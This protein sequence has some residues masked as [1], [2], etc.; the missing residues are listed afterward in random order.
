[1]L[2]LPDVSLMT[3]DSSFQVQL[4]HHLFGFPRPLRV[5]GHLVGA[6]VKTLG[7]ELS[8]WRTVRVSESES[9]SFLIFAMWAPVLGLT[10]R[11]HSAQAEIISKGQGERVAP[12]SDHSC[13]PLLRRLES[14]T[15]S[16]HVRLRRH[17]I[18]PARSWYQ[19]PPDAA[20][21]LG[22]GEEMLA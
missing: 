16:H 22:V 2:P 10:H 6:C 4:Q 8:S 18:S 19:L 20:D 1:M 21:W 17:E 3:S 9:V 12:T 11:K 15:T 13:L 14:L 7:S 5:A